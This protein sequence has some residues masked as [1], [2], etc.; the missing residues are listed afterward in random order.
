MDHTSTTTEAYPE[1]KLALFFYTATITIITWI[2]WV[3]IT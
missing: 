2:V 3:S 1:W